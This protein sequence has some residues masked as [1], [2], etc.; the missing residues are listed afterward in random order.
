MKHYVEVVKKEIAY[1]YLR[2]HCGWSKD[3]FERGGIEI[4]VMACIM[5]PQ[6][7]YS[8]NPDASEC[9]LIRNR[10]IAEVIS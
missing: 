5:W 3:S 1:I 2:G 4:G 7:S 8:L 9:N 6:N 10:V